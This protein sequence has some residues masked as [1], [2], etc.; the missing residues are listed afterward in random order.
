M[1]HAGDGVVPASSAWLP[2]SQQI[3][4]EGVSHFAGFGRRWYGSK[5]VIAR[6][7]KECNR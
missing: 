2:G 6:W 5:D 3:V 1:Q 7:W 4:L